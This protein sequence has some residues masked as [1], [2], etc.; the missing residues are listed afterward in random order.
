MGWIQCNCYAHWKQVNTKQWY[1]PMQQTVRVCW[2]QFV[3]VQV[4][5][6]GSENQLEIEGLDPQ[7]LAW[8]AQQNEEEVLLWPEELGS[9]CCSLFCLQ[10][11]SHTQ[12]FRIKCERYIFLK[13]CVR[14]SL[15]LILVSACICSRIVVSRQ[16]NK[17]IG[18]LTTL[19]TVPPATTGSD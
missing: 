1:N 10:L 14:S 13:K 18:S 5:V 12:P 8:A 15:L 3:G 19:K 16:Y 2:S 9:I 7:D 11:T 6:R 4:A 17:Q